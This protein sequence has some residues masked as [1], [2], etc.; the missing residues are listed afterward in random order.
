MQILF[1]NF[2]SAINE[3]QSFHPV[4][5]SVEA[6]SKY[7]A[8]S[9]KLIGVRLIP[10]IL[11]ITLQ[12]SCKKLIEIGPPATGINQENVYATDATAIAAVTGIY[13]AMSDR[14]EAP[15]F[16][17]ILSISVSAGLSSDELTLHSAV[18]EPRIN[19]YFKNA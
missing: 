19:A 10:L 13:A 17:G 12:T 11:V 6:L 15:G 9:A 18:T 5:S 8:V 7:V 1:M 4:R 16:T 2:S 14:A 3:T